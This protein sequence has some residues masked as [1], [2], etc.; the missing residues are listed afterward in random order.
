MAAGGG[1]LFGNCITAAAK[2]KL[3]RVLAYIQSTLRKIRLGGKMTKLKSGFTPEYPKQCPCGH[4]N[5]SWSFDE[6]DA[7]CWEC[8]AR[9]PLSECFGPGAV[10]SPG[11]GEDE[12]SRK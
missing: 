6:K 12:S 1:L 10:S 8:N 11:E 4:K 2:W 7:Y 9:Y 3:P 5:L